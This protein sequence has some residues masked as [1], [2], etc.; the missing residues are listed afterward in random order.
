V[1]GHETGIAGRI[2]V[3]GVPRSGT[4][5]VQSLLA[6]HDEVT[7]FTESHLFARHFTLLPGSSRAV[8]TRDPGPRLRRFLAEN[9]VAAPA[10]AAWFDHSATRPLLPFRTAAAGRRLLRVLDEMAAGRS[11]PVWVEKTPRHLRYLPFLGRLAATGPR[12][13]FVH[14]IR[15]GLDVV[16]SLRAASRSWERAYDLEECARRWNDDVAFSLGRVGSPNDRFV[17]YEEL[18]D[19]P[20]PVLRRLVAALGLAWQP[21][22][23]ERDSVA[24]G[25]LVTAAEAD[26]KG[27]VGRPIERSVG[28]RARLTEDERRRAERLLNT[29]LYDTLRERVGRLEAEDGLP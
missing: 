21:Q 26:W 4:T 28:A 11:A 24:S 22:M 1:S 16:A 27:G 18:T 14:V 9:G 17:L 29:D 13:C 19:D 2:F 25:R 15:D 8:L 20:E 3:V 23:L 7:S 10:A 12:T 6:A 5:L